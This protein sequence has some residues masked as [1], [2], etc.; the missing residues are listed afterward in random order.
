MGV[1]GNK[2]SNINVSLDFWKLL[3][4]IQMQFYEIKHFLQGI[5]AGMLQTADILGGT[6]AVLQRLVI[7]LV[8][9]QGKQF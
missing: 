3:W 4:P 2:T 6:P 8:D 1:G 7:K 5:R 9:N